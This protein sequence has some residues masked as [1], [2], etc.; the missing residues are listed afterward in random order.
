MLPFVLVATISSTGT[1]YLEYDA[2]GSGVVAPR[3]SSPDDPC[4]VAAPLPDLS[5]VDRG[6][7]GEPA[8][9][10]LTTAFCWRRN[11][12]VCAEDKRALVTLDQ[13]RNLDAEL[14][15]PDG[16]G[17]HPLIFA[18]GV[19]IAL[20]GGLVLGGVLSGGL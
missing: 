1:P 12:L 19:V 4:A 3:A 15:P 18:G 17:I 10:F 5:C 7:C 14:K 16:G 2:G 8:D 13:A 11:F 9:T 20:V 6:D